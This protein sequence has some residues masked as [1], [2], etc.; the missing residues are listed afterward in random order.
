MPFTTTV[1][2]P[3]IV[4][5]VGLYV[6]FHTVVIELAYKVRPSGLR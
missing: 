5:S 6:H 1:E 3:E 2:D 4:A